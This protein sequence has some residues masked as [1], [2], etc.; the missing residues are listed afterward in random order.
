MLRTHFETAF[1][2]TLIVIGALLITFAVFQAFLCEGELS[3]LVEGLRKTGMME[4]E[5]LGRSLLWLFTMLTE[6]V[7][8][9]FMA[10]LGMKLIKK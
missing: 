5:A 10:S 2:F 9:F 7:G 4:F 8:G 3:A 6:L 1:A